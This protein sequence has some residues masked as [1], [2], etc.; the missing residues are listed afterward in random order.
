MKMRP[1]R[2]LVAALF[3]VGLLLSRA[4]GEA[5]TGALVITQA[6]NGATVNAA[7]G[8][9]I[10]VD[11]RG[12]PSTGSN[13]VLTNV[14]GDS[15]LTN[16]PAVY[17]PDQPGVVG[18]G[19]TFEFPFVAAQPGD[20]ALAFEY[21]RLGGAPLQSFAVTIHVPAPPLSIT[22]AKTNVVVSWPIAGST[23]C[24][25]EGATSLEPSNWAALNVLPLPNGTNYT[26]TLG[27]VGNGLYFRLHRL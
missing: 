6:L 22:L 2:C 23:N 13:W 4:T 19:G 20:T 7:V 11:L 26:V 18:G 17:T 5:Q 14:T 9:A 25:L 27:T 8:Q 1:R 24:F 16:G 3:A 15:V 21:L 12:N 10:E